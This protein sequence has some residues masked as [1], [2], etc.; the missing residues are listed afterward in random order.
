MKN[1]DIE[2]LIERLQGFDGEELQREMTDGLDEWCS[3]RLQRTRHVK[4]VAVIALLLLTT[5]AIAMTAIP[6]FIAV[7][8]SNTTQ[9][10][11]PE[12]GPQQPTPRNPVP[13][14][15]MQEGKTDSVA[16]C[17][18]LPQPVDYY[19]TGIA[20]DGYSVAYG[21]DTRTLTYTRYSGR[22]IISSVV[23]NA[24]EVFFTDTATLVD[25]SSTDIDSMSQVAVRSMIKC[26]FQQVE[27]NGDVLYFSVTDSVRRQVSV[28]GDVAQ[29]MGQSIR[30]ND[31]LVLP[32]T[33][34]RN[35]IIYTVT[36]LAD[37]A[38]ACHAE[39][40]EVVLPVTLAVIGDAAFAYCTGLGRLTV[41]SDTPPEA[42]PTSF[43]RVNTNT[44]LTVPCGSLASYE[45]VIEWLYFRQRKENCP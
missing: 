15:V 41:L 5:T 7:L 33:V 34:E 44:L 2:N 22:H 9:S 26:D 1:N 18:V 40:R 19:Y 4:R 36:A 29:W 16:A 45:D 10:G 43:N 20:E 25:S 3:R 6:W 39:L 37:S 13:T 21:H 35:G 32:A 31:T 24:P 17:P 14:S 11:S 28:R 42:S 38:F 12:P 27:L 30:Y 8:Q 23:H